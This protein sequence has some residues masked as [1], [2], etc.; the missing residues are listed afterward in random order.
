MNITPETAVERLTRPWHDVLSP[1][2]TGLERYIP[3]DYPPLLDM[4]DEACRTSVSEAGAGA[5]GEASTR[6]LINLEAHMLRNRIDGSVKTWISHLAKGRAERDTKAAVVQLAGLL[7]A[8][9]ASGTITDAE[10]ARIGGFFVRWCEQIWKLYDPPVTKELRG[11]CPNPDCEAEVWADR[12]GAV[13]SSLVAFYV[14]NTGD[15]RAK[16]RACGWEWSTP[17]ELR[18]LGSQLGAT[19]DVEFL[20]AAGL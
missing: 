8:H 17:A 18:L 13:G 4:L 16:C 11:T 6:S 7:Q 14:R 19:Q 15:V 9:R 1:E 20:E 10:H 5:G 2:E 12:D 3:V